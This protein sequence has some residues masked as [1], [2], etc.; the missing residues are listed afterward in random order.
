VYRCLLLLAL[1]EA[2]N[3]AARTVSNKSVLGGDYATAP[4]HRQR[5]SRKWQLAAAVW[6]RWLARASS[7]VSASVGSRTP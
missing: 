5:G 4:S 2:P 1:D 3:I 6:C 7:Y